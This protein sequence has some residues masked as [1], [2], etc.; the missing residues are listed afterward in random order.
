MENYCGSLEAQI[1]ENEKKLPVD[2]LSKLRKQIGEVR[3]ALKGTDQKL[4]EEKYQELKTLSLEMYSS[5][6]QNAQDAD[7]KAEAKK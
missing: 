3:E 2:L 6:N 1:K 7:K 5:I 4:I